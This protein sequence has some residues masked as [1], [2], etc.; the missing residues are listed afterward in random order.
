MVFFTKTAAFVDNPKESLK[1]TLFS[2]LKC[3][4]NTNN[5]N[6]WT[7]RTGFTKHH[8]LSLF[9]DEQTLKINRSDRFLLFCF[10]VVLI[11]PS[12]IQLQKGRTSNRIIRASLLSSPENNF[13]KKK[14]AIDWHLIEKFTIS[15]FRLDTII[16]WIYS[17]HF[18]SIR[19]STI[20]TIAVVFHC[21][22]WQHFP[23]GVLT[24]RGKSSHNVT[25]KFVS[26]A[27]C[28]VQCVLTRKIW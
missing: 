23:R 18:S 21:K 9:F 3:N 6:K 24:R 19:Y 22:F 13:N 8:L 16:G 15:I 20:L 28:R 7:R 27:T 10:T 11:H 1:T 25:L 12:L 5:D 4:W 2:F 14:N 26:R 17:F